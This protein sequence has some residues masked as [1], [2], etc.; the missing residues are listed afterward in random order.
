[1]KK[2]SMILVRQKKIEIETELYLMAKAL[3]HEVE[4]K[5]CFISLSVRL[6]A[7]KPRIFYLCLFTSYLCG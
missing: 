2:I 5:I 6:P 4:M 7:E 1:M 3:I